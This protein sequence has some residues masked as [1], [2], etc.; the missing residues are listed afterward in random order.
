M[1][2]VL[3]KFSNLFL[4]LA[5]ICLICSSLVLIFLAETELQFFQDLRESPLVLISLIVTFFTGPILFTCLAIV[6]KGLHK[7]LNNADY[8]TCKRI[9]ELKDKG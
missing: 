4:I 8:T 6:F 9:N 5:V 7:D 3:K 2:S 1:Y